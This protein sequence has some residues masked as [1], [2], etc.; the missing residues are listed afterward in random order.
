MLFS[1][2]F[3][4]ACVSFRIKRAKESKHAWVGVGVWLSDCVL[5]NFCLALRFWFLNKTCRK[6]C[7][8][9]IPLVEFS[10]CSVGQNI[11]SFII[12]LRIYN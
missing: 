5:Y 4:R 7:N 3:I 6:V 1:G 8:L 9:E 10:Y 12:D 2:L 11:A